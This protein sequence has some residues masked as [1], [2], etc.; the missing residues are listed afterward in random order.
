MF[1]LWEEAVS[2]TRRGAGSISKG[3]ASLHAAGRYHV[4]LPI[5][6]F[7]ARDNNGVIF[8]KKFNKADKPAR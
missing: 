4:V 7:Q 5:T 6:D 2:S 1:S 8:N 3:R